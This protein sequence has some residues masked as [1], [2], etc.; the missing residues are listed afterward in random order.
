MVIKCS[1]SSMLWDF[2]KLFD[3]FLCVKLNN[4]QNCIQNV[5]YFPEEYQKIMREVSLSSFEQKENILKEFEEFKNKNIRKCLTVINSQN[6]TGDNMIDSKNC[7]MSFGIKWCED[8][9]YLWDN[10]KY[11]DCMDCYSGGRDSELLYECTACSASYNC[12]FCI[13]ANQSS[14]SEYSIFFKNCKNLFGCIGLENKEYCI[15]NKQYTKE[16]YEI[17]LPKIIAHMKNTN[18]YGEFFPMK[19]STSAYNETVAEEYFPIKKEETLQKGLRWRDP[20]TKSYKVTTL[21]KNLPDD[22]KDSGEEILKETIGCAHEGKC[23]HGCTTAFRIIPREFEFYKRMNVPLPRLCPNCR[24]YGRLGKLNPLKL[25]PGKCQCAGS[26]SDNGI[27]QNL[28]KHHLHG[29]DYCP[30]EFET[31]Y[32]PDRPEIIYCEKCYQQEIY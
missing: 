32:A 21:P 29:E 30:N 16:K 4:K 12:K 25:W 6:C 10:G 5:Q 24:H 9:R 23:E 20:D 14:D 28:A 3:C 26:K 15:F 7:F 18:E 27:Y 13:R 2:K 17:L 31:S 1:G 8:S 19:L 11:K 22:I